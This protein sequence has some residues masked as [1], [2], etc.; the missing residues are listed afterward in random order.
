MNFNERFGLALL[1]VGV[2]G[3]I[4]QEIRGNEGHVIFGMFVVILG[5]I[6]LMYGEH[7]VKKK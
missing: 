3:S 4:L 7:R 2:G 1:I 5:V 6:F